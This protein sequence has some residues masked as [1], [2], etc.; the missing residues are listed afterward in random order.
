M[1]NFD[2]LVL[3]FFEEENAAF[4]KGASVQKIQQPSRRELVFSLRNSGENR[5]LYVN[6]D[7]KYPHL[8]FIE[9][10]T[11]RGIK[12]PQ[13]P[14]M[15]CMQLRK[16][17]DGARILDVRHVEY[18]RIL[19]LYF[20]HS[21]EIGSLVQLCLAIE[22]MGKHSN[23]ILYNVR[24]KNILGSMHN[25]SSEKS[26]VREVYGGINYIYP[27]AQHKTDILKTSYGAFCEVV[28]NSE[29][30]AQ[31]INRH[32]YYLSIPLIEQ[33]IKKNAQPF[34]SLQK[35][36]SG[37]DKSALYSILGEGNTINELICR[38][39]EDEM[40]YDI[41]KRKSAALKK[42]IQKELKRLDNTVKSKQTNDKM[43]LYKQ[44]G[45][46]ILQNIYKINP[47]DAFLE[48]DDIKIELDPKMSPSQNAQR[49]FGLYNKA[50]NAQNI[51]QQMLLA[52]LEDKKYYEE[53]LFDVENSKTLEE[54]EQ[55]TLDE[56]PKTSAKEI[57]QIKKIVNENW[58][59]WEIYIGKNN[60]QNDYLISK[61]ARGEDLWL[62]IKDFPSSH[63]ILKPTGAQ[64]TPPDELLL[65]AAGLVKENSPLKNAAKASV[66]YTKRKYLKKPPGAKLGY[67]TYREESEIIV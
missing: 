3:K 26:S 19:E 37:E 12:I 15:F 50:K 14:P 10:Y 43:V 25:I 53:L 57:I 16:Y 35:L 1:Y 67:V 52:A 47:Q 62:H 13:H 55:I 6:I 48:V 20:N 18:E 28:K 58:N 11:R 38:H 22:L 44:K 31:A 46:L 42:S 24:N 2:S 30:M 66:I 32:Y 4:L 41:F 61:I 51:H 56:T 60:R 34:E 39:F 64:K 9:D 59:D 49:Y 63:I 5:K 17:F 40:F 65:Y 36:V 21:D 45:D 23:V 8:C 54:L 27:P 29:N 33:V 7:P